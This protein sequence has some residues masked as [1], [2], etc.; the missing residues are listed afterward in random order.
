[1]PEDPAPEL[2]IGRVLLDRVFYPLHLRLDLLAEEGL[3]FFGEAL[4]PGG[5]TDLPGEIS[6][7]TSEAEKRDAQVAADVKH[8]A[9]SGTLEQR[10]APEQVPRQPGVASSV[11]RGGRYWHEAGAL[12]CRYEL[13]GRCV[14]KRVGRRGRYG[15][16]RHF[17]ELDHNVGNVDA[18]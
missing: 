6:H 11:R 14:K 4:M 16:R 3:C 13:R 15:L 17:E 9:Y 2:S 10:E 1:M 5:R 8:L 12:R 18:A 7:S